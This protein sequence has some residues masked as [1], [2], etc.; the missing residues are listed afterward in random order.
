MRAL[1]SIEGFR[2]LNSDIETIINKSDA[3]KKAKK[4]AEK[5]TPKEKK[6]LSED[7]K[8]YKSKRKEIQEKLIKFA[9]RI[10]IFMKMN[11]ICDSCT[12]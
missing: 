7:E 8:E 4:D 5:L 11:P 9:T 10:P 1:M 6:E 2:S 3:V 12:S